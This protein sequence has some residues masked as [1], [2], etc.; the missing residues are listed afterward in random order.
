MSNF[1]KKN[2]S[3]KEFYHIIDKAVFSK[4]DFDKAMKTKLIDEEFKTR[5]MLAVTEINGCEICNNYHTKEARELAIKKENTQIF[6]SE[7]FTMS[8]SKKELAIE[9]AENYALENG[10]Y[11]EEKWNELID[12]YGEEKSN[13]ILGAIRLIMMGNAHG[14][15]A[16]ALIR[17]MKFKPVKNSTFLNEL[18]LTLSVI[19]FVPTAIIKRKV[20]GII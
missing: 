6:N 17:R 3:L 5:I 11:S 12:Y 18:A 15:A 9:F 4:K 16:G 1:Y 10:N 8:S 19:V 14:I 2:Y 7:V 20:L 13:A